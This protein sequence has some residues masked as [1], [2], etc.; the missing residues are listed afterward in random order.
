MEKINLI[1]KNHR[2]SIIFIKVIAN[3]SLRELE[4]VTQRIM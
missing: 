3:I 1:T 2:L 4:I